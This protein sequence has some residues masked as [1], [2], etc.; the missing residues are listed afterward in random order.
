MQSQELARNAQNQAHCIKHAVE[1]LHFVSIAFPI[2]MKWITS[3]IAHSL[4]YAKCTPLH[5]KGLESA[6]GG[7]LRCQFPSDLP[8]STSLPSAPHSSILPSSYTII[9]RE[10]IYPFA[11]QFEA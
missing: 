2:W 7:K 9:N 10:H 6:L 8:H 4:N 11:K 1:P 3:S 5:V